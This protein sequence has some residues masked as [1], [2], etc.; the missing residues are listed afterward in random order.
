MSVK[1]QV[2]DIKQANKFQF[3]QRSGEGGLRRN[4]VKT[5]ANENEELEY[6]THKRKARKVNSRAF[7]SERKSFTNHTQTL[8]ALNMKVISRIAQGAA[9]KRVILE[10]V[11]RFEHGLRKIKE[12]E[13]QAE[14]PV[15]SK[16][17]VPEHLMSLKP[18]KMAKLQSQGSL[19]TRARLKPL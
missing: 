8:P 19:T 1:Y 3:E 14:K 10:E 4:D 12:M 15:K 13:R 17:K 16:G 11:L 6:F 18:V 5:A 7:N 9:K 2:V